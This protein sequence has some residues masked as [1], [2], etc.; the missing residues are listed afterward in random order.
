MGEALSPFYSGFRDEFFLQ[1]KFTPANGH[2]LKDIPYKL[3]DKLCN[4]VLQSFETSLRNL[5]VSKIDSYVLH[6]PYENFKHT[7]E[8]WN[9]MCALKSEGKVRYVGISNIYSLQMLKDII[10]E[11]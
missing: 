2:D 5:K 7:L 4:Q 9:A 10:Q 6:S 8:V 11:R 1:T 3:D